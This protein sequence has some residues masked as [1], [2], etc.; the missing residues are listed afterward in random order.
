M[1]DK[2]ACLAFAPSFEIAR[3]A[4]ALND[5]LGGRYLVWAH[6]QEQVLGCEYAV[7]CEHVEQS[8]LREKCLGEIHKVAYRLIVEPCPVGGELKRIACLLLAA[9]FQ[10]LL[11]M[12]VAGGVAVILGERAVADY[13]NLHKFK[14]SAACPERFAVVAAYLVEGFAHFHASAFQ[15]HVHQW[16]TVHKDSNIVAVFVAAALGHILVDY[17]QRIVVDILFVDKIDVHKRAIVAREHLFVVL[18][19]G[20][21]F[22]HNALVG[23]AEVFLEKLVP[24]LVGKEQSVEPLELSTEVVDQLFF[25]G[26]RQIL[27][28]LKLK[29]L[30]KIG[31]HFS[32]TLILSAAIIAALKFSHHGRF[33][34][35]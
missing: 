11:H 29:P 8:V 9:T 4:Y 7:F 25:G 35:L 22:F 17:L 28:C 15:L 32:L 14:E 12:A 6:H 30:D 31:F 26:D 16:Q 19:N 34:V 5:A 21:G 13:E 10:L 33:R 18:L 2:A 20:A 3:C 1:P 23:V 24:F 27:V